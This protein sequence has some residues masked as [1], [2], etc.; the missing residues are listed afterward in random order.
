MK[1]G[2]KK[3]QS[4]KLRRHLINDRSNRLHKQNKIVDKLAKPTIVSTANTLSISEIQN[5]IE[6][7]HPEFS[8]MLRLLMILII[9]FGIIAIMLFLFALNRFSGIFG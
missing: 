4:K 6:K 5:T 2:R 1:K 8:K 9:I 7:M 3:E